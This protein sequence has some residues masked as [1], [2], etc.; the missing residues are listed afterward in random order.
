MKKLLATGSSGLIRIW[1]LLYI[2]LI[3]VK[4]TPWRW[5]TTREGFLVLRDTA[6]IKGGWNQRLK[7]FVH[8]EIDIRDHSILEVNWQPQTLML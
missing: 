3:K 5:R 7:A 1:S 8:H 6:G 4:K 2:L